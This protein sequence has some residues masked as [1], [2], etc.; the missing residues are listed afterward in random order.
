MT[1]REKGTPMTMMMRSRFIVSSKS[2]REVPTCTML[3]TRLLSSMGIVTS[4]WRGLVSMVS[5]TTSPESARSRVSKLVGRVCASI[6][7]VLAPIR[8]ELSMI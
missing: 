7:L 2:S 5:Y 6:S 1:P 3:V 8:P 4:R